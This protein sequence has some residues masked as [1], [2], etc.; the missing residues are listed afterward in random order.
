MTDSSRE[1]AS[2]HLRARLAQLRKLC[3]FEFG[4]GSTYIRH[5]MCKQQEKQI[6][7]T[8]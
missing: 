1:Q 8:L 5:Q 3:Q 7:W 4:I 2:A 6:N